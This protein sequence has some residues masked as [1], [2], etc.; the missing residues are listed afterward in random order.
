M[1]GRSGML[2]RLFAPHGT[3]SDGIPTTSV[4]PADKGG[5]VSCRSIR[6]HRFNCDDP[7]IFTRVPGQSVRL[8][9]A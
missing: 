9:V 3:W 1:H 5:G 8:R 7:H 6:T 2:T 4:F